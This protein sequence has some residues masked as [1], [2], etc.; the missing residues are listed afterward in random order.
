M[1]YALEIQPRI[2]LGVKELS[3]STYLAGK[4]KYTCIIMLLYAQ[5]YYVLRFGW[6]WFATLE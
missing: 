1:I 4:R 5:L 2:N 6:F 3:I